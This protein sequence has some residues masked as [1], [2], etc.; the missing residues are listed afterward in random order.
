VN[1]GD[2]VDKREDR[3]RPGD[4]VKQFRKAARELGCDESEARFQE[5]L[6]TI[7]KQKPKIKHE[8]VSRSAR[9]K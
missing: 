3:K 8:K 2:I 7:A 9:D 5:A 4:Q 1:L 6:R